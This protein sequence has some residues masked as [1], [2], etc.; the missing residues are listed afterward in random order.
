MEKE[1]NTNENG[2]LFFEGEYLNGERIGKGKE[3]NFHSLEFEGIY[4]NEE[5][6]E[7]YLHNEILFLYI[8]P[9]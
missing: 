1:K 8:I 7:Y 4:L 9:P 3:Y 5:G 2:I 6:K